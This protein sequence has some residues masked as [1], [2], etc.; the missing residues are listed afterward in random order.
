[1]PISTSP[2]PT[3]RPCSRT[4]RDGRKLG[5][6][7]NTGLLRVLDDVPAR[8][9]LLVSSFA[10]VLVSVA[11]RRN[12][13]IA[14]LPVVAFAERLDQGVRRHPQRDDEASATLLHP[15]DLARPGDPPRWES[16]EVAEHEHEAGRVTHR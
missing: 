10:I 13:F 9:P 3:W 7:R 15:G 6:R 11:I 8:A 1:C 12:R 14:D 5:R 16:R 2:K 4:S